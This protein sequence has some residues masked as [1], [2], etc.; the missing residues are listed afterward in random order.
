MLII[1]VNLFRNVWRCRKFVR[2]LLGSI[3]VPDTAG[4]FAKELDLFDTTVC[5]NTKL[6]SK[7]DLRKSRTPV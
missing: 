1:R 2:E 6:I 7:I 3:G 4:Y 5:I